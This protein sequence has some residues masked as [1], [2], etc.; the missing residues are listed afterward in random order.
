MLSK[1]FNIKKI[2]NLGYQI[3]F[4]L[5]ELE[6]IIMKIFEKFDQITFEFIVKQ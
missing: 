1:R 3:H 6:K 2:I 5:I 4:I